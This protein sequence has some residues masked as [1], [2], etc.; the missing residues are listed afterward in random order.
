MSEKDYLIWS[1]VHQRFWRGGFGYTTRTDKAGRFS[2]EQAERIVE[3]GNAYLWP[4][5]PPRQLMFPAPAVQAVL[6][7][8]RAIWSRDE[9]ATQVDEAMI[10]LDRVAEAILALKEHGILDPREDDT[11]EQAEARAR[12]LRY[13][14]PTQEDES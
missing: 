3:R 12:A 14:T 9:M 6:E 11:P 13:V 7:E 1:R 2:K 8:H 10:T 4:D 5:E